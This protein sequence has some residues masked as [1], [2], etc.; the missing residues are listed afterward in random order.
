MI[1]I[2]N[3]IMKGIEEG[4]L[5]HFSH[6]DLDG[7]GCHLVTR[8][9][10]LL[11]GFPM[12]LTYNSDDLGEKFQYFFEKVVKL[13]ISNNDREYTFLV[14]DIGDIDAAGF[15]ERFK[16][17]NLNLIVI[18]HHM[19]ND[20]TK[21]GVEPTLNYDFEEYNISDNVTYVHTT[22]YAATW[23]YASIMGYQA[24]KEFWYISEYDCGRWGEWR[25]DKTHQPTEMSRLNQGLQIIKSVYATEKDSQI[26]YYLAMYAAY[27][28]DKAVDPEV[29]T[30]GKLLD[31][32][33]NA[34]ANEN[35][36]LYYKWVKNLVIK[37]VD[38]YDIT[39]TAK[40]EDPATGTPY[41]KK[42]VV[43]FPENPEYLGDWALIVQPDKDEGPFSVYAK[44]Y[45]EDHISHVKGIIKYTPNFK[46]I[47]SLRSA[48]NEVD[49]SLI[50]K[51]NGGGGHQRAAGFVAK[52]TI[53][54]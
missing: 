39:F 47:V 10:A 20:V 27:I 43:N 2:R 46:D 45:L 23:M 22:K 29:E 34:K 16:G 48:T 21:L 6:T 40:G 42:V 41:E 30:F 35:T 36:R 32:M 52:P 37:H 25:L 31:H 4:T 33:V 13:F 38:H 1:I 12:P 15:A 51:A 9:S 53:F 5:I 18:D 26:L 49:V 28:T 50:A 24:H 3:K 19:I 14:T 11:S 17:K 7:Y 8:K 54:M 44:Q